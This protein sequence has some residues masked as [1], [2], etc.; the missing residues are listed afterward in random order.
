MVVGDDWRVRAAL[1]VF[2]SASFG[3][4]VVADAGDPTTAYAMARNHGP[5]V[6][7]VNLLRPEGLHVLRALAGPWGI[8]VV[9]V[10]T[11]RRLAEEAIAAGADRFLD[12]DLAPELMVEALR[13]AAARAARSAPVPTQRPG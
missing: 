7:L 13:T 10:G 11:D 9:A 1:H 5:D 8:P 2:L 4:E 3:I 6:A 12:R